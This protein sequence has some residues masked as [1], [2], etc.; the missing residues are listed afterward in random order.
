MLEK[1]NHF[2]TL[3]ITPIFEID[4]S[5]LRKR[6]HDLCKLHHPDISP[7]NKFTQI[8]EAY[9]TLKNDYSR[10]LY[11]YKN[12]NGSINQKVEKDFLIQVMDYEDC[13]EQNKD[14]ELIKGQIE[15]EINKCR[16]NYFNPS[17][18]SK[19]RYYERLLHKINSKNRAVQ[20]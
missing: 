17:Y 12:K 7:V 10:A 9:D 13:I 2:S 6:Y 4:Q 20:E 8:K 14:L 19:W 5:F 16:I 3:N 11:M 18:L 1:H 15:S